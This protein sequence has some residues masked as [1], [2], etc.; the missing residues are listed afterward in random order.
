MTDHEMVIIGQWGLLVLLALASFAGCRA[1]YTNGV[2]DGYGYSREPNCPGYAA[3]GGY[4]RKYMAHRWPELSD[5][6]KGKIIPP[7][8]GSGTA[9]PI[10]GRAPCDPKGRCGLRRCEE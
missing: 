8:G 10:P 6:P 2:T 7:Q 1:A 5:E 4:L 9:R 3:A